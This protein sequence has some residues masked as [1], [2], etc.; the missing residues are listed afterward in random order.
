MTIDRILRR[1]EVEHITGLSRSTIHRH[2]RS[3]DF[4][5]PIKLTARLVGWRQSELQ[6][7]LEAR[8]DA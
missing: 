3:G 8:H 2:I 6:R 1:K 4:P 7:W 5:I